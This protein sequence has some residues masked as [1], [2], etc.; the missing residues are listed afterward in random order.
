[1]DYI[2]SRGVEP[3]RIIAMGYGKS[4]PIAPNTFPDGRDNPTGRQKNR[5]TEFKVLSN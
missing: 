3:S 5:R 2:I 1:V 4:R